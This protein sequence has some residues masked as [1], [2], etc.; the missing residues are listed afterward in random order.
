MT[1][2]DTKVPP[3]YFPW[4]ETVQGTFGSLSTIETCPA[5]QL[6]DGLLCL[7]AFNE[8]QRF[9]S[10]GLKNLPKAFWTSNNNNEEKVRRT[11]ANLIHGDG[12]FVVRLH[13]TLYDKSR[14]LNYFAWFCALELFG[15]VKPDVCPPMTGRMAKGMRYLGFDV[16]AS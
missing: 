12:D 7:H 3:E 9:V 15:T 1:T 5:E 16:K 2:T 11:L 6:V 4:L 14:K 10:G 8:Q 13:D